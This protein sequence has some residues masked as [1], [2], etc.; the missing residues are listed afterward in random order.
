MRLRKW[1]EFYEKMDEY[2]IL[3]IHRFLGN[4]KQP[5]AI[6]RHCIY[7]ESKCFCNETERKGN[8]IN[9]K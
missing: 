3:K 9:K 8:S 5:L 1:I 4:F 7:V 6:F 2:E